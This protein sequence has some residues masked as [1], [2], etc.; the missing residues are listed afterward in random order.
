MLE[1]LIDRSGVGAVTAVQVAKADEALREAGDI[2]DRMER[3]LESKDG[4]ANSAFVDSAGLRRRK[5]AAAC[6]GLTRLCRFIE[7]S[8]A[9]MDLQ[10]AR[11]SQIMDVP[12]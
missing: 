9:Q 7:G 6:D 8:A 5:Y 1:L 10:D 3:H 12:R 2:L 4:L 11:V